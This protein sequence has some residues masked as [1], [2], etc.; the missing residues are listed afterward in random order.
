MTIKDLSV[1]EKTEPQISG[2]AGE[3]VSMA[4]RCVIQTDED[5]E[6]ASDL[7]KFIKTTYKKAEE[8]RKSITDPINAS[9]KILNSR[10]KTIT[11]PLA[12][13]E[14]DIKAKILSYELEKRKK[15]E[16]E[17]R[18]QA[19]EA[20]RL[21]EEAR[22]LEKVDSGELDIFA[23]PVDPAPIDIV[24]P[25]PMAPPAPIRGSYGSTTSIVKRWTYEVTDIAALA[26]A[27]P[28]LVSVVSSAIN[29][30]I[31]DGEREIPGLRIYQEETVASR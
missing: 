4:S 9:V 28:D 24:D 14:K 11:D 26:N 10:F 21:A 31:R 17:A 7:L 16:E 25:V 3:L 2:R 19:E 18:R 23:D 20:A 22:L 1:I 8:E 12:N 15:A 6:K 27:C 13:A 5:L 29:Q 30:R